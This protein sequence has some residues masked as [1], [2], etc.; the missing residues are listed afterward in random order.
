MKLMKTKKSTLKKKRAM[1]YAEIAVVVLLIAGLVTVA[2]VFYNPNAPPEPKKPKAA[3][4][5]AFSDLGAETETG[6]GNATPVIRIKTLYLAVT[7]VGGNATSFHIDPGGNTDP[8]DYYYPEI[9]NGTKQTIEV[10]L[11]SAVQ[12]IKNGTT[13][14]FKIKVYC[15]E[16]DDNAQD[17]T[18]QI[19]EGSVI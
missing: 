18:L 2:I 10:T 11:T 16:T 12:S 9:K 4:Y 3:D 14:P 17:V 6:A 13:Y 7:P 1:R 5:F 15:A 19:P 8:V